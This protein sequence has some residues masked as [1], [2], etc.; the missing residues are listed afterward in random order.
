MRRSAKG[1]K[2]W[3]AGLVVAAAVVGC[4]N[5]VSEESFDQVNVGMTIDDVEHVLGK[6]EVD[7]SGGYSIS[8]GGVIGGSSD[9]QARRK[10]VNYKDGKKMIIVEYADNKVVSK[11][12]VGF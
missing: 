1:W 12:K 11:R 2:V 3:A 9:A 6:G 7:E 10:T 5:K 8:S 4:E